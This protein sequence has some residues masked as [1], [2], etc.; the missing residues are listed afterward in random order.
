[1]CQL[2]KGDLPAPLLSHCPVGLRLLRVL[3]EAQQ[4]LL[5]YAGRRMDVHVHLSHYRS[6]RGV[7]LSTLLNSDISFNI[8]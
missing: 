4:M 8:S 5:V 3:D 7:T 6:L 2:P 1:M